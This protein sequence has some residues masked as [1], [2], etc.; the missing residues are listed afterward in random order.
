MF[1]TEEEEIPWC[2]GYAV[3]YSL[4]QKYL[5]KEHKNIVDILKIKPEEILF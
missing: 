2:A 4:V 5:D 1:G 3:G